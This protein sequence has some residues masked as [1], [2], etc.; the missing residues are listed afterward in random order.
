MDQ[1]LALA[2]V[3]TSMTNYLG[4][5]KLI[6]QTL[7]IKSYKFWRKHKEILKELN[8]K[9]DM[10]LDIPC[11]LCPLCELEEENIKHMLFD[12]PVSAKLWSKFGN[13]WKVSIPSFDRSEDPLVWSRFALNKSLEGSW[14]QVAVIAL[15][16]L[17]NGVIFVKKKVDED[18]EFRNMPSKME[19]EWREVRRKKPSQAA[20][21]G[22]AGIRS[23]PAVTS[24][25]VCNLPGDARK[26]ELW[27]ECVKLGNLVDIYLV[28]RRDSVGLFFAFVRYLDVD[29]ADVIE[30]GLN[31]V[32]CRGRRLKANCAKNPT[33]AQPKKSH[34]PAVRKRPNFHYASRDSRTF[35][36]ALGGKS[37]PKQ[38][39]VAAPAIVRMATIPE[40]QNWAGNGV[41]VGVAK[42]FDTLCNFPSLGGM[43][44]AVKFSSRRAGDVFIANKSIWLK[45]F[46][47]VEL[48]D[49]SIFRFERI[50][51]VK[52]AGVPPQAWDD[53]NFSA[54]LGSVTPVKFP[55]V[56]VKKL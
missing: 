39:Q 19:S 27:K 5:K 2:P 37:A 14:F 9:S 40:I 3:R 26:G 24:F 35:A 47:K 54:I 30:A 50:A 55:F 6:I 21:V 1:V 7:S 13:W 17:R 48:M 32:V 38:T 15:L 20:P 53:S 25:Y 8:I 10:G 52:A 29:K 36:D 18:R 45:W 11:T 16:K 56:K 22:V 43:N 44:V 49:K 12:C 28:G 4:I 31:E 34:V 46:S 23:D 33:P 42:N 51:W 41:L